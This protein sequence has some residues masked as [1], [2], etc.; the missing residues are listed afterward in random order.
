MSDRSSAP[1]LTDVE[2]HLYADLSIVCPQVRSHLLLRWSP[3]LANNPWSVCSHFWPLSTAAGALLNQSHH[4]SLQLLA[5]FTWLGELAL[6]FFCSHHIIGNAGPML[7]HEFYSAPLL[8]SSLMNA[9]FSHLDFQP[10]YR[11]KYIIRILFFDDC[12]QYF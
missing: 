8:A 11:I 7:G 9:I 1:A 3:H 2:C 5:V 4:P 12:W 10:E 6:C